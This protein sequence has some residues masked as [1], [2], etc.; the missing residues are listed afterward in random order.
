MGQIVLHA[1]GLMVILLCL[2]A[3]LPLATLLVQELIQRGQGNDLYCGRASCYHT[4]GI[5]RRSSEQELKKSFRE[6]AR[7]LH[8]D[9]NPAEDA[10]PNFLEV[11]K[12]HDVLSDPESRAKYD[13]YLDHPE[14]EMRN[15]FH[16]ASWGYRTRSGHSIGQIVWSCFLGAFGLYTLCRPLYLKVEYFLWRK[17][18]GVPV[19]FDARSKREEFLQ[20][21]GTSASNAT[22]GA[23]SSGRNGT[24]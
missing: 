2:V 21:L 5:S 23:R 13:Y 11:G 10:R 24:S 20:K 22:A 16:K 1:A 19:K 9:K 7:K 17:W 18:Y 4:L 3:G 14:E 6:L 8:P 12:A 15:T